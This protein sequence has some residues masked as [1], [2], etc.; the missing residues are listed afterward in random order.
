MDRFEENYSGKKVVIGLTGRMDSCVAALLLKKQGMHVIGVSLVTVLGSDYTKTENTPK[1]HIWDL[2]QVKAFC[3]Q[4]NI[5]F[6]A[7]D[8]KAEFD[9]VVFD[10]LVSSK[11]VG[12]ANNSCFDCTKMRIHILYQKMKKLKADYIATGHYCKIYKNINSSQY[13]VHANN[14][15]SSDQSYML[16]GIDGEYLKHLIL[17]LGELKRN[18][19]ELI[20]K[21]FK[22]NYSPLIHNSNFC[23]EVKSSY[24]NKAKA[25]IPKT[26]LKEGQVQ[27]ILTELY[28]GDHEGMIAFK[29][30]Q[31]DLPFKGL[32]PAEAELEI[33]AY[34]NQKGIIQIGSKDY[35]SHNGFQLVRV[36]M[37]G[38]FDQS[39][40]IV[41]FLKYK[42]A[43]TF[44]KANLYFKNN[45]SV[46]IETQETVYPVIENE[47]FVLFDRCT[48]NAKVI[49]MGV[50]GNIG[51]FQLLDRVENYR[52]GETEGE[53]SQA[54][55]RSALVFKF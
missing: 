49:G 38:G 50:V 17:P 37:G 26:L 22:L 14:D 20:A 21:K 31:K 13:F 3:E 44:Y 29:I 12:L 27:N 25:R 9:S 53:D 47:S 30:G 32:G 48:R 41:C 18:E 28:H 24:F 2:D 43:A 55:V 51:D 45:N 11:I 4:I 10:P 1:C 6:F 46:L 15:S 34:N 5:P 52:S 33:V 39:K 54:L 19:V 35:L 8:A 40:P 7:T 42:Y 23:F 16:A 36:K